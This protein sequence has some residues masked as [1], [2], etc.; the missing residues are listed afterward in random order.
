ML[1]STA[2]YRGK[3]DGRLTAVVPYDLIRSNLMAKIGVHTQQVGT[4]PIS[5]DFPDDL[6]E[7]GLAVWRVVLTP[8]A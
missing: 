5:E 3:R 8:V 7:A 6:V 1:E 4:L 2:H